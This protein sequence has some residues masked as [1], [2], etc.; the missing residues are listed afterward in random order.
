MPDL[1]YILT[2]KNA[3]LAARFFFS[4]DKNAIAE[5]YQQLGL[6][7]EIS[8]QETQRC[9]F[10]HRWSDLVQQLLHLSKLL[11]EEIQQELAEFLL[12]HMAID[13]V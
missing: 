10:E 4:L 9:Y 8:I 7:S 1:K 3:F 5:K 11:T 2:P 12:M 13:E 6:P